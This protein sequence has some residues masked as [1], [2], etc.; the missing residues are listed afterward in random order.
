MIPALGATPHVQPARGGG[1]AGRGHLRAGGQDRCYAFPGRPEAVVSYA[2]TIGI[3]LIY[4]V[5]DSL[6]FVMGSN[7]SYVLS[8]FVSYL[9]MPYG[10][11]GIPI[12]ISIPVGDSIMVDRVYYSCV[13]TI[14]GYETKV[15][16]LLLNMGDF[17]VV[18]GIHWLSSYH[19]ILDFHAKIKTLS[20]PGFPRLEWRCSFG[21]TP[22]WEVSFL[23]DQRMV[24]KGCLVYLTLLEMLVL[25]LLG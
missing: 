22:S 14:G 15:D 11:L 21:Y 5:D 17:E 12:Y 16:L 8:Y 10:S 9:D 7:Y 13:V 24:E 1:Q 3:V 23:N 4:H 20:M 25:I 19:V 2:V 6:L 18:L